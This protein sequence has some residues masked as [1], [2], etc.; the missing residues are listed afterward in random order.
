MVHQASETA[1]ATTTQPGRLWTPCLWAASRFQ[2]HRFVKNHWIVRE[3]LWHHLYRLPLVWLTLALVLGVKSGGRL[4]PE[5]QPILMVVATSLLL[6]AGILYRK[7]WEIGAGICG[8]IGALLVAALYSLLLAPPAADSLSAAATR[9]SKPIAVR[10]VIESCAVWRPNQNYRPEDAGSQAWKTQWDVR[11]ERVRDGKHWSPIDARCTLSVAGRIDDLLPGDYV[12]IFGSFRRIASPSNPGAFDFAEHLRKDAKFIS[13]S[14]DTRRQIEL[15]DSRPTHPARR[16]RGWAV[17]AVDRWLHRWVAFDQAPLA[18]ALVFGQREQVDWEDQQELMATGTLHLLAI[19]GMHVDIVACVVVFLCALL[20]VR[21]RT[22]FFAIVIVCGLYAGLAGGK[23]PVMRAFLLVSAFTFARWWV[24]NA[25]LANVLSFAAIA[26][27]VVRIANVDNVGVHLSFL[28]VGAIGVFVMR[29]GVQDQ[30][31]AALRDV[32]EKSLGRTSRWFLLQARWLRSMGLLSFWVWL[33]TCPLVWT[34]FHVVAPV[35]IVLNVMIALPLMVSLL[36]GLVAGVLGWIPPVGWLAGQCC[37]A[38]LA[39]ICWL[40]EVGEAVPLGHFWLPAPHAWWSICFYWFV[41]AW[42]FLFGRQKQGIL[43]LLL[44][45]WMVIGVLPF[46]AGPRGLMG[47]T[48]EAEGAEQRVAGDWAERELR[49]TFLDVGHG[50]CVILE[51]PNRQVWLYDAGNL[52][53]AERSYQEIAAALWGLPTARIHTL[54]IS[55][56]D[57]DHY[58]A[59]QGLV[60]R[61]A[62]GRIASTRMFWDSS[63]REVA[64]L[65]QAI[66]AKSIHQ[67]TWH[68]AS[69]GVAGD[70][71]W[72]VLHPRPGWAGESDNAGSLCLLLE[73]A[74][75]RILLPGDLE[76]SGLLNLVE[77][78]ER[79]CHVL[80]APHHG[81]LSLDPSSLLQWCLPEAIVISGNHRASRPMVIKKYS[82]PGSQLGITFRDGAIQIRITQDGE[83][84]LWYWATDGWSAAE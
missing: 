71:H 4:S 60:E 45:A 70:V 10:A 21:N 34:H 2:D 44:L 65:H 73:F 80:M 29:R 62:V 75:K 83:L 43:G 3:P 69:Q 30:R 6:L 76:G 9:R 11:C 37:G 32:V 17:R 33:L 31:K 41:A 25:S 24:R 57:A 63:D 54:V 50:T 67:A 22:T 51:M 78:P 26:L 56:A 82:L 66:R 81:S 61:F 39:T 14:A 20:G 8:L 1:K 35:A 18:A 59:V 47:S 48:L 72:Q 40:V 68:A 74:G 23:P 28:A 49:C 38:G 53:A 27:L 46:C 79:P 36:A 19:S 12:Q 77:L 52:G 13:L 58:N 15:L 84:S 55:H 16:L 64:E 7:G 42:L 5:A